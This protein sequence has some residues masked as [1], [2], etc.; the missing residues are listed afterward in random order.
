MKPGPWSLDAVFARLG[1]SHAQGVGTL[2]LFVV[3]IVAPFVLYP[4]FLMKILCFAQFA[5][6]FNLLVGYV[7]LLSFGHAAYF[8]FGSYIGGW[9]AKNWGLTAELAIMLGGLTGALMG[10]V[11]GW[12]SIR[13]SGLY[14]SMITLALAQMAY[15]FALQAPFTGGEDGLQNVPRPPLFGL[16]STESDLNAYWLVA[17][18]FLL[19]FLLIHRVV[20]SP[21]GQVLKGIRDNEARTI[22]LGYR[23]NNY[24]L[25][26][27][28]LSAFVAGIAGATK[29]VVFGL[30]T[31]T[32]VHFQMSGNVVLMT[33]V[34]GLGTIFGPIAGAAIM[35]AMQQ[36]FALFAE[37][38]AVIQGAI[39]VICVM[40]FR[41]GVVGTIGN[42]L[43]V[44]L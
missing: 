30:A 1:Y 19:G 44:S 9:T 14:F 28:I 11:F 40:L 3:V 8:G 24:K 27:F 6:A 4:V 10:C 36:Y 20:H 17:G 18:I 35:T 43:K 32:D 2:L 39:F 29:A 42:R 31:L 37:W 33:L 25:L 38:V 16:I 21:F 15:F 26:A 22:S 34:G 7:G 23:V 41:A 5:C 12:L 13:R